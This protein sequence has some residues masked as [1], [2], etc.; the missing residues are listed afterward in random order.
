M[1]ATKKKRCSQGI[2]LA[3]LLYYRYYTL[4]YFNFIMSPSD[5]TVPK[6]KRIESK[7]KTDNRNAAKRAKRA[8]RAAEKTK[9]KNERLRFTS[10]NA[11]RI[12][13][14]RLIEETKRQKELEAV[15]VKEALTLARKKRRL[16][17]LQQR[18]D[19][20]PSIVAKFNAKRLKGSEKKQ[21]EEQKRKDAEAQDYLDQQLKHL[22]NL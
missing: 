11:Y 18:R 14:N 1:P 21:F 6:V 2:F 7:N 8:K 13:R 9:K 16:F 20:D 22:R 5:V 3:R 4:S 15:E 12:D 10:T 17:M 19:A